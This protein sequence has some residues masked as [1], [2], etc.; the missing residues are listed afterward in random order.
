MV[1]FLVIFLP[2]I[3]GIGLVSAISKV[4]SLLIRRQRRKN[5]K[6]KSLD[7]INIEGENELSVLSEINDITIQDINKEI[8]SIDG[9]KLFVQGWKTLNPENKLLYISIAVKEAGINIG[10]NGAIKMVEGY[11]DTLC[12]ILDNLP[13]MGLIELGKELDK[14]NK[15]FTDK[16]M[17]IT[18]PSISKLSDIQFEIS[19]LGNVIYLNETKIKNTNSGEILYEYCESNLD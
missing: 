19:H 3:G 15:F 11:L 16:N 17:G 13:K 8:M 4:I 1:A 5:K 12:D 6:Y 18:L 9:C 2:I 7:D 10:A 14:I